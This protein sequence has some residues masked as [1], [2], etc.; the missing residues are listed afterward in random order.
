[1]AKFDLKEY[2]R[3]GAMTRAAELQAELEDIYRAFPDMRGNTGRRGARGSTSGVGP[4]VG[5][6]RK[7]R[8]PMSDAQKKAVSARMKKY[9]SERRKAKG[10]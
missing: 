10:K 3:T 1:L 2:A 9:W 4:R 6:R 5:R 8:A 7:R